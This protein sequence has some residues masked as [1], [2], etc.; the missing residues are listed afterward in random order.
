[1]AE[2]RTPNEHNHIGTTTHSWWL[3]S[4]I[5]ILSLVATNLVTYTGI[6]YIEKE[7]IDVPVMG[8]EDASENN[9]LDMPTTGQS[10]DDIST[11]P[12]QPE[13]DL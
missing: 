11:I 5:F 7:K 13:L 10:G 8:I 2:Q 12:K 3:N 9:V 4:T 6:S 1:M